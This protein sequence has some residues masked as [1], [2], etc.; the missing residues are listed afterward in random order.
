MTNHRKLQFMMALM[1]EIVASRGEKAFHDKVGQY[2][3]G[4]MG[5]LVMAMGEM[6]SNG[7]PNANDIRE[8]ANWYTRMHEESDPEP[9]GSRDTFVPRSA[10]RRSNRVPFKPASEGPDAERFNPLQD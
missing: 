6:E 10:L 1:D 2:L 3:T 7:S 9:H 4:A 5:Y 8:M